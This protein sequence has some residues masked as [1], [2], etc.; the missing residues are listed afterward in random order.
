MEVLAVMYEPFLPL[1]REEKQELSDISIQIET[2][3]RMRHDNIVVIFQK[4]AIIS[5]NPAGNR[6]FNHFDSCF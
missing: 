5:H 1:F 4:F 6:A 3:I 2:V